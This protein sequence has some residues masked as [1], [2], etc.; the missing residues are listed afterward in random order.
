M[1]Q[2]APLPFAPLPLAPLPEHPLVSVLVSCHN[3]ERFVVEAVRSALDQTYGAVEVIV[4]DDGSDDGSAD[5]V[6]AAF[7]DDPRVRL[8]RQS[9]AG[10]GA[11]M[12][13][14]HA[15]S[16]GEVLCFLD[17]DDTFQRGK[18]ARVVREFRDLPQ[19]GYL[20]HG[21]EVVEADGAVIATRTELPEPG[22]Q[23][24]AIL[25]RGGGVPASP[26]TSAMVLRRAAADALFPVDV[27]FRIATDALLQR[28]APLVTEMAAVA[29][30]LMRYRVHGANRFAELAESQAGIQRMAAVAQAVHPRQLAFLADRYGATVADRLGPMS[31]DWGW[32]GLQVQAAFLSG[33]RGGF[34]AAVGDLAR[35]PDSA[36]ARQG[37]VARAAVALPPSLGWGLWRLFYGE[38]LHK[39]ALRAIRRAR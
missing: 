23:A 35:H 29:E 30:P 2:T 33:D 25:R 24:G 16:H 37:A 1:T 15:A 28:T 14:A 8:I 26:P 17:A 34:R 3:Y 7:G 36:Q 27:G 18:L 11:A 12:N 22:W 21:F 10:Q 38:G 32:L 5:R 19:A 31:D 4:V 6:Q 13:A 39:R 20:V 9:N